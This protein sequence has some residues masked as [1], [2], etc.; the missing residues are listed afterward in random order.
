VLGTLAQRTALHT[1]V[2]S[3]SLIAACAVGAGPLGVDIERLQPVPEVEVLTRR[4]HPSEASILS[5]IRRAERVGAFLALWT[6]KESVTKATGLRLDDVLSSVPFTTTSDVQRG[7]QL[8]SPPAGGPW[9]VVA[10]A[11]PFHVGS[12]CWRD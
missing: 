2:S 7:W 12:V 11:L 3:T 8:V 9:S 5:A 4:L 1:S 6:A 10:F